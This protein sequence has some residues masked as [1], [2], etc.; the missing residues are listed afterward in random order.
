MSL[1]DEEYSWDSE[2]GTRAHCI[3]EFQPLGSTRV[4]EE[5]SGNPYIEFL[6][7]FR[8]AVLLS[9]ADTWSR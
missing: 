2:K 3:V 5:L 4:T 7:T 6:D 9:K 8:D 1:T